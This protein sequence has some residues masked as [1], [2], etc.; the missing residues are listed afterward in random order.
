MVR[1]LLHLLSHLFRLFRLSGCQG[2]NGP[3]VGGTLFHKSCKWNVMGRPHHDGKAPERHFTPLADTQKRE[4]EGSLPGDSWARPPATPRPKPYDYKK[5]TLSLRSMKLHHFISTSRSSAGWRWLLKD[6]PKG[7]K[8]RVPEYL[9]DLNDGHT[10]CKLRLGSLLG[11]TIHHDYPW[12][13]CGGGG[14]GI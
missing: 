14:G 7:E 5:V 10:P 3:A 8:R 4:K 9:D 11:R 13:W 2:K 1:S 6:G 12:W